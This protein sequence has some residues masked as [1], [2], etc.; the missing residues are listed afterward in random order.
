MDQAAPAYQAVP[1][2]H[3]K[4]GEDTD[5]DCSIGLCSGHHHHEA[6][7]SRGIP[8]H[9]A[10]DPLGHP[11]RKNTDGIGTFTGLENCRRGNI[12]QPVEP[13]RRLAGQQ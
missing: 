5:L 11:I 9:F 12:Q 8:P 6:P 4:R 10:T 1:W 3:P 2:N 13:I 7:Q